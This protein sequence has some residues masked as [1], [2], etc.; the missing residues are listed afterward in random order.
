M[1][2]NKIFTHE[3][4]TKFV[5]D[6]KDYIQDKKKEQGENPNGNFDY[7]HFDFNI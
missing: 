4:L 1:D 6:Y 5:D 2:S 7:Y 3:R